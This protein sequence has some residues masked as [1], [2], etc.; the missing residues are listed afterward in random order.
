MNDEVII[1]EHKPKRVL[2]IGIAGGLAQI[3]ARL[4]AQEKPDWQVIGVDSRPIKNCDNIKNVSNENVSNSEPKIKKKP[5]RKP[6]AQTSTE[7]KV[8]KKRL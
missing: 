2:I 5:G 1:E 8:H 7:E 4:I 3:T 6:K